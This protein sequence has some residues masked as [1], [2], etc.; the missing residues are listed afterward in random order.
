MREPKHQ[1]SKLKVEKV[2]WVVQCKSCEWF[3]ISAAPCCVQN[4]GQYCAT[5]WDQ[6]GDA[7]KHLLKI[8]LGSKCGE[9]HGPGNSNI[10]QSCSG[11]PHL[12]QQDTSDED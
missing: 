1:P 12:P 4:Y 3:W 2:H 11:E 8:R 7:F 6:D 9:V 5:Q 10:Q